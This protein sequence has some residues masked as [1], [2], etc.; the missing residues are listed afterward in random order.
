MIFYFSGTGNS[1]WVA[2]EI[3]NKTKDNV[4]NIADYIKNHNKGIDIYNENV[5]GLVF[6]IYAWGVPKLVISFLKELN[7]KEDAYRFAICTCGDEAGL[8]L[9]RLSRIF[10]IDAG[11][12]VS[13]PNNYILLYDVDSKD[14]A[15]SKVHGASLKIPFIS[16][17]IQKREKI[18]DVHKGTFPLLKSYVIYPLFTILAN[19]TKAFYQETNCT[20]CGLCENICPLNNITLKEGQPVW[21]NHCTQ[22]L[23][24]LH[25]CPVQ[26]IQYGKSTKS[27]ERYTFNNWKKYFKI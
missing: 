7:V 25:R 13:M 27:K 8:A 1:E 2:N 22:C 20:S 21:S 11:W 26:A 14:L 16:E 4:F 6:P 9:Q 17:A 3:A 19:N 12:S 10:P 23:A 24:C 15:R 18:W 5:I